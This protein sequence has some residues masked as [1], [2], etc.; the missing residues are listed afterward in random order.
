[1]TDV[2][3]AR[4][5][6]LWLLVTLIFLVVVHFVTVK[7]F[8]KKALS[9]ANFEAIERVTGRI[10]LSQNYLI[11]FLMG[12]SFVFLIFSAA[13]TTLIFEAESTDSDFVLAIDVSA[14]MTAN[15][16]EPNRLEAA[17]SAALSFINYTKGDTK[18]ALITFSSTIFVETPLTDDEFTLTEEIKSLNI[19]KGGGTNI[20]EAITTGTNLLLNSDKG[21]A[22]V[23]LTD[24]RGNVGLP[25]EE[26]IN[27][28][29]L[30]LV[31]V[32]TI[33]VG[34]EEGGE[35]IEGSDV[36]LKVD[37]NTLQEIAD[38]TGGVFYK[39]TTK[40]EVD[41][42]YSE[43]SDFKKK[44]ISKDLSMVLLILALVTLTFTWGMLNI[45]FR[46]IP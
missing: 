29:V 33:G 7:G 38:S 14:S 28:A 10:Q 15:D 4:P 37:E 1:M 23:L 32:H 16:F 26:A 34:T 39:A 17:K 18:K 13:G 22:I 40:E 3:F 21:R 9:F 12:F 43:I 46:T 20:G 2:I 5:S 31:S 11:L 35:I 44:L 42:A 6:Y 27:Y 45:R 8:R 30:N 41:Q 24:G 19:R 36:L 25:L